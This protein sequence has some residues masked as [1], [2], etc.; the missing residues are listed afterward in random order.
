MIEASAVQDRLALFLEHLRRERF[1]FNEQ[2]IRT[3]VASRRQFQLIDVEST[4]KLDLYPRELVPGVL[5]RAAQIEIMLGLLLPVSSRPDLVLSKLIWISMGSH[6]S[7]RDLKQI[8][9]R[10]DADETALAHS[11]AS[12]MNLRTLLDEVLAEPDEIDA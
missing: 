11:L 6:K 5:D 9:L 1:L 12:Q 3:A 8:M 7:R 10:A 2:T 4:L